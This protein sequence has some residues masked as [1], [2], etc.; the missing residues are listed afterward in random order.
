[1]SVFRDNA[2]VVRFDDEY[3]VAFKVETHN[4]PS[5]HRALRRREHGRRRRDSRHP[6]HGP[7]REA[8]LQHRRVLLRPAR[9]AGG[10]VAAGRAAS[11]ADHAGRRRGRARLWQPD[12]HSD[13]QRRDL[14]RPALRRQSARL[15]RQRRP[16]AARQVVQG[17]AAGRSRSWPS[18]AARA[19]MAFT[20]RR[21]RASN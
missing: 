20:A 2:G 9:H 3:N 13:G 7:G 10:R 16:V 17:T 11:A 5:R 4:R 6:R 21:F 15:L 8:D 1:M 14:F 18:A 12:G 19:A